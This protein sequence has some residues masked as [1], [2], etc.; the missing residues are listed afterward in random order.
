MKHFLLSVLYIIN[1]IYCQNLNETSIDNKKENLTNVLH[2]LD[3]ALVSL[4]QLNNLAI[5]DETI[6]KVDSASLAPLDTSTV[7]VAEESTAAAQTGVPLIDQKPAENVVEEA[8]QLGQQEFLGKYQKILN[9]Y[10][11]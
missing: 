8:V 11:E 7:A 4:I 1:V 10:F 2:E 3:S 6:T 9:F 5:T